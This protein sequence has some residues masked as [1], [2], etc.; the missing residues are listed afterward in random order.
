M[1][2]DT[3]TVVL[4]LI[5]FLTA[6]VIGLVCFII[7]G[8]INSHK[9]LSDEFRKFRLEYAGT[10]LSALEF[11]KHHLRLRALE[12]SILRMGVELHGRGLIK[13]APE[14]ATGLGWK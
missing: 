4:G 13:E 5:Q 3:L 10:A 11:E 1:T 2:A 6:I 9:E 14:I 8:I 7:K 12:D